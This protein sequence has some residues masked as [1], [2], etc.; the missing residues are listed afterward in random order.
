ML[1]WHGI[2]VPARDQRWC[3]VTVGQ[4]P[5]KTFHFLVRPMNAAV[6]SS[7]INQ[8][9]VDLP[10]ML[11]PLNITFGNETLNKVCN[12]EEYLLGCSDERWELLPDYRAMYRTR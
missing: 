11:K 9:L 6:C 1:Q 7:A 12:N 4:S 3:Y 5:Q 2:E 10:H 8:R